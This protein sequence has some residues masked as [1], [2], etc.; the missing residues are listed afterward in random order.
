MFSKPPLVGQRQEGYDLFGE[1][2]GQILISDVSKV[3]IYDGY[4]EGDAF[5]ICTKDYTRRIFRADSKKD[6]A[7]WVAAINSAIKGR[8]FYRR[9]TLAGISFW[10][11]EDALVA[12]TPLMVTVKSENGSEMVVSHTVNFGSTF[13][14][15]ASD[16]HQTLCFLFNTGATAEISTRVLSNRMVGDTI[17]VRVN[18]PVSTVCMLL[19]AK[20]GSWM[21]RAALNCSKSPERTR[22]LHLSCPVSE[23]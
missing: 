22:G 12:P 20:G 8:T 14:F 17:K 1:E 21:D 9:E 11:K 5:E 19:A 7:S 18:T 2:R 6:C 13:M 10:T 4:P 3:D 16:P 15:D 23:Y